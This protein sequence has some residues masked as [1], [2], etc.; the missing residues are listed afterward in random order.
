TSVPSTSTPVD[1]A[2]RSAVPAPRAAGA[3]MAPAADKPLSK[4]GMRVR[5]ANVFGAATTGVKQGPLPIGAGPLATVGGTTAP[6]GGRRAGERAP[7]RWHRDFDRPLLWRT[8]P[9]SVHRL[10]RA[11][12][13]AADWGRDAAR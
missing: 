1:P 12:P 5:N 11:R 9:G 3:R 10:G 7:R 2:A 4:A 6:G 13:D 8:H